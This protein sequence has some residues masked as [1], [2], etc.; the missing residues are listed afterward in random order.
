MSRRQ[1][2]D[3]DLDEA[4]DRRQDEEVQTV[5]DDE[6][7]ARDIEAKRN[8]AGVSK[9]TLAMQDAYL[10]GQRAGA[11]GVAAGLNPWRDPASPEYMAWERGRLAAE[12]YRT[13][14]QFN[15]RRAA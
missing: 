10:E 9:E 14:R 4:A 1:Y 7:E 3:E 5:V 8:A 11:Q 13:S 2:A 6:A 12:S 15:Q